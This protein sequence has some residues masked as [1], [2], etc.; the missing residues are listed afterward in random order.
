MKFW[1]GSFVTNA[2]G[3]LLYLAPH[4]HEDVKVIEVDLSE[5]DFSGSIGRSYAI[6]ESKPMRRSRSDF[7]LR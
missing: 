3:R 6:A 2:Q 7:F 5:S 4:D 1:G